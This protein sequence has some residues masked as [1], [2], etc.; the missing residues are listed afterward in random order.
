[1]AYYILF[2]FFINNYLL[3]AVIP[4]FVAHSVLP[5]QNVALRAGNK[6][7]RGKLPLRPS[8]TGSGF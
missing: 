2:L 6:I 5:L 7:Q 1:M 4:T 8:V 3:A